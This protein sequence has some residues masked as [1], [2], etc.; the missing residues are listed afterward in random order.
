[1][2]GDVRDGEMVLNDAGRI[3]TEE[4]IKSAGIRGEIALDAFVV[5]PNHVHGIIVINCRGDRPV[6]PTSGR[7]P[8]GPKPKS[9]GSFI[10]GFKPIVTKSVNEL[11]NTP[12]VKLWQ[13]NYYEHVIRNDDD[14]TRIRQYI[15]N[16]PAR[17]SEDEN[18]P[19]RMSI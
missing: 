15:L 19:D 6:A 8:S 10:G 12:G 9:V 7:V 11:C 1:M 18:N 14:M 16:N 2:F 3:V 4:W 5:M 17:W 13:R